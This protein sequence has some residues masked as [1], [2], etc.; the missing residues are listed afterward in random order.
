VVCTLHL[1]A[2]MRVFYTYAVLVLAL[3]VLS[4]RMTWPYLLAV[5][6]GG[7]LSLIVRKPYLR[8]SRALRDYRRISAAAIVL[9]LLLLI[10][11][12]FTW[13]GTTAVNQGIQLGNQLSKS[14]GFS[15]PS[16]AQGLSK[17]RAVR[18]FSNS[19]AQ[20]QDQLEQAVASAGQALS[21]TLLGLVASMPDLVIQVFLCLTA[22][23]FFLVDGPRF[24]VWIRERLPLNQQLRETVFCNLK[25]SSYSVILASVC[26]AT[27]Q[28]II[29]GTGYF[30]LGLPSFLLA[31]AATFFLAWVPIIG[32]SPLW[33][34]AAIYF[35][36]MDE[37][38]KAFVM[39]GFGVLTGVSDNIVYPLVLKGKAHLHP[40]LGLVAIF[41]GIQM[42]GL[43][44]VF[45]GPIIVNLLV[46][47]LDI[48][49]DIRRQFLSV[50]T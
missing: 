22:C 12:P 38:G 9:A 34:G 5:F 13:I 20:V 4:L 26:A 29:L 32:S 15:L 6:L 44:G 36:A 1:G 14:N 10:L 2:S 30:V 45:A 27:C 11:G 42:F 46:S 47:L 43:F 48:L 35:W 17:Y 16:I 41:G 7:M 33:I 40:L 3:V 23:Y 49:P 21:K 28:S 37:I 24:A 19:V 18:I 8:L 50:N 25:E 31:A 39:V